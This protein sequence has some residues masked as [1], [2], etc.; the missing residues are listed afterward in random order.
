M[1]AQEISANNRLRILC[2][3]GSSRS[4]ST[5]LGAALGQIAGFFCAGE[6][7]R[8]WDKDWLVDEHCSCGEPILSCPYWSPIFAEIIG[9]YDPQLARQLRRARNS[10]V[11]LYGLPRLLSARSLDQ[12]PVAVQNY[13]S[14]TER[15][16]QTIARQ[17]GCRV[18]VD[19]SKYPTYSYL[20]RLAP[21]LDVRV[22]HLVRDARAVAYS[23]QRVKSY[24][25]A[26]GIRH[27][28]RHTAPRSA[29]AWNILN[30]L[31]DFLWERSA[32]RFC[33]IRYEDFVAHPRRAFEAIL[34]HADEPNAAP[35]L[36]NEDTLDIR[37][38]HIIA[39]N[40]NRFQTGRIRLSLDSEWR[41][42]LRRLDALLVTALTFP[43]LRKYGYAAPQVA[44]GL[45]IGQAVSGRAAPSAPP[46]A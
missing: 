45:L 42:K 39:G 9:D 19:T 7:Q 23:W 35:P 17:T 27:M 15:L 22:V 10:V 1:A 24:P 30:G 12:L 14:L 26:K 44:P 13:V 28:E 46:R 6:M 3:T 33:L 36:I 43:L 4:G 34:N 8:I 38:H 37:S 25:T 2:I 29:V 32:G 31:A 20:L 21:S 41:H 16:Y 11:R 18:I 40:A 5:I